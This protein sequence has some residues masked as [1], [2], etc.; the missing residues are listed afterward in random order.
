MFNEGGVSDKSNKK[1]DEIRK[2]Y[3]KYDKKINET[4]SP[5]LARK[6]MSERDA[7]IKKL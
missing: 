7:E 4:T 2:I 6:Y 5:G 3:Q 1:N